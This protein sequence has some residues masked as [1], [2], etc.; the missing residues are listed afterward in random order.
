MTRT[1]QAQVHL[2]VVAVEAT[3]GRSMFDLANPFAIVQLVAVWAEL[4]DALVHNEGAVFIIAEGSIFECDQS[5][6]EALIKHPQ[7]RHP[8]MF[9]HVWDVDP[10]FT[11]TPSKHPESL[12]RVVEVARSL[13][14]LFPA[15]FNIHKD[16][17]DV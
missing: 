11:L 4:Q 3:V 15:N 5:K 17:Q 6:C 12:K 13:W 2:A 9:S 10:I 1:P 16:T 8:A 14:T 7:F